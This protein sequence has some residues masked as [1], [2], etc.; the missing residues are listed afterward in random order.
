MWWKEYIMRS[1]H[2]LH[3][4]PSNIMFTKSR[5][6]TNGRHDIRNLG[7]AIYCGLDWIYMA[8]NR[9][10]GNEPSDFIRHEISSLDVRL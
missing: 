6:K 10:H 9:I 3:C 2:N 4:L 7:E 8:Q 1:F 5:K